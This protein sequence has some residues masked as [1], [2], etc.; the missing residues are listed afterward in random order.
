MQGAALLE[1]GYPDVAKGH[2]AFLAPLANRFE[3]VGDMS[4]APVINASIGQRDE[5]D[6][7]PEAFGSAEVVQM[8]AG[9]DVGP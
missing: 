2:A 4:R 9:P 6:V 8:A 1:F 3:T 7:F 5:P